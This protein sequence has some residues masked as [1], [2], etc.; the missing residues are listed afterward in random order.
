MYV[1]DGPLSNL[2]M[3]SYEVADLHGINKGLP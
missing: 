3:I 2:F 1:G